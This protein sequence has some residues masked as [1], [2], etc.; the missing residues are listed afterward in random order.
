[1]KG[2]TMK[3]CPLITQVSVLEEPNNI[4]L[5]GE[6]DDTDLHDDIDECDEDEEGEEDEDI[7]MNPDNED[8]SQEDS[9]EHNSTFR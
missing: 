8:S 9:E 5:L 2:K 4:I 3:I 6:A 7:F 1:M